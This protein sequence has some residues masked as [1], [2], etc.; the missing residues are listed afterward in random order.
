M[1]QFHHRGICYPGYRWCGPGC[2]GPGYP[3]NPVDACCQAHDFC[4]RR[5]GPTRY[6]DEMFLNCL[7]PF[8]NNYSKME[9]TLYYFLESFG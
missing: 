8:Q 7:R 9:E 2:S 3:T 1:D 4:Y 6:C 5:F